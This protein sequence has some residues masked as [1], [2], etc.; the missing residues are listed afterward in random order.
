MISAASA[1]GCYGYPDVLV[2]LS[3][4]FICTADLI[5]RICGS[6]RVD[7][8]GSGECHSDVVNLPYDFGKKT[9][10]KLWAAKVAAT[11]TGSIRKPQPRNV[12]A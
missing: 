7:S 5:L 9:G 2:W 11:G 3:A 6:V 12:I 1:M 8:I 4:L 10:R